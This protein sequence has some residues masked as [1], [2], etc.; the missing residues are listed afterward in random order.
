MNI[1]VSG[2]II[3]AIIYSNK[4]NWIILDLLSPFLLAIKYSPNSIIFSNKSYEYNEL[5]NIIDM[6]AE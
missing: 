1:K 3:F 2:L 5:L 6:K 4:M